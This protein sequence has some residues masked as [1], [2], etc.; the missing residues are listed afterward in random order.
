[1]LICLGI[2]YG[3]FG[4]EMIELSNCSRD[5]M[6]CKVEIFTFWPSTASLVIPWFRQISFRGQGGT[7]R[8]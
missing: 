4:V 2:S 3:C 8:K 5:H 7:T 6:A 1:M